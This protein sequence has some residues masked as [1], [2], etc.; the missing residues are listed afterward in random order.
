MMLV[1]K[2]PN[3][4]TVF[5]VVSDQLKISEGWVRCGQCN[6]I[7]DTTL[8]LR[9]W[10]PQKPEDNIP[11]SI[12]SHEGEQ[13]WV[14][15]ATEPTGTF[16]HAEE[17]QPSIA[18]PVLESMVFESS[19]VADLGSTAQNRH[20]PAFQL[21]SF[22][23]PHNNASK[24]ESEEFSHPQIEV[25]F[26]GLVAEKRIDLDDGETDLQAATPADD[27]L[28]GH[29]FAADTDRRPDSQDSLN[30]LN[31][32]SPQTFW[33]RPLARRLLG[34]AS[35]V[36]GLILAVQFL[37]HER[38]RIST[39]VPSLRPVLDELCHGFGCRVMPLRQ[40]ESITVES[41]SFNRFRGET[42][43][44]SFVIRNASDLELA[45]PALELTL[46][47]SQDQAVYR[48]VLLPAELDPRSAT[49]ARGEEWSE[50]LVISL[51]DG[52]NPA[53]LGSSKSVAGYRLL[54][55]YP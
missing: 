51:A 32:E 41:S 54:A 46:T 14:P 2:C 5:K 9:E 17:E 24:V 26:D 49:M 45:K 21:P 29:G 43:R 53:Q 25:P 15:S 40:I 4:H 55:F 47:D 35:A 18:E 31:R 8:N 33:N 34:I 42:Y 16:R 22:Q 1:T 50:S 27:S 37:I 52:N 39:Y 6:E 3:C 44:L 7:F 36:L 28:N 10:D 19:E 48:R 13:A 12:V 20:D 30:F 38:D 23:S 11:P